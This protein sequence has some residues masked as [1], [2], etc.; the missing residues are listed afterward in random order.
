MSIHPIRASRA[1]EEAYRGYLETTFELADSDLR[2][3]FCARLR[4][5]GRLV[6]GP[7]VQATM[8]F[9]KAASL[10]DLVGERVLSPLFLRYPAETLERSLYQHQENAIRKMVSGK[11][12]VVVATGTGSGKTECF[13]IPIA[14]H[15][16]LEHEARTRAWGEAL[17]LSHERTGKRPGEA[18]RDLFAIPFHHFRAV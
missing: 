7:M 18:L 16:M 17:L 1:I 14:N 3:Q 15:L 8:P 4:E 2:E 9:R 11:R 6:R 13:M 5:K 10:L 12:N